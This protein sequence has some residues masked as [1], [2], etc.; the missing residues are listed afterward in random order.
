MQRLQAKLKMSR[1]TIFRDLN[2]L[3]GMGVEIELG[4]KGYRI[5]QSITA[6][7]KMLADP[8]TKALGKLLDDCLK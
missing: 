3:E 5:K 6:C 2:A 1:R 8:Q 7:R 4:E